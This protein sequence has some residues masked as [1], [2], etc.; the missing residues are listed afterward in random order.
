VE[1]TQIQ[2]L[3]ITLLIIGGL[4]YFAIPDS[5][6]GDF[7]LPDWSIS[8]EGS[9]TPTSKRKRKTKTKT[10]SKKQNSTK[11]KYSINRKIIDWHFGVPVYHN[12]SL[13]SVYGRNV[14]SDG[15]NL[16]LK[17]Q[18]VE[19]V[20]R[21]YY[22]YYNHKM[23]QSYGHAKEFFDW[24]VGD[25]EFNAKRGLNQYRNGSAFPPKE[26]AIIIFRPDN[27]NSF[28]HVGIISS[29]KSGKVQMISQNNGHSQKPRSTFPLIFQNGKYRIDH[30]HVIGWLSR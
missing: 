11:S 16:G 6:K 28:G 19:F 27:N 24:S 1:K 17:Y 29:I 14:T 22:E 9:S 20:K 3:V 10:K 12:G 13:G 30:D 15:Y 2:A 8:S 7:K 21:F 4:A 5:A 23:T 26:N 25:G 18:C